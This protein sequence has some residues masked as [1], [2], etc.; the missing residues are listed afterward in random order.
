VA[1]AQS[2]VLLLLAPLVGVALS[3][4]LLAAMFLLALALASLGVAI[5]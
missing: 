3:P 4:A 5:A 1:V 2:A